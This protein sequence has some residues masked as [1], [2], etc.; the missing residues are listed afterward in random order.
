MQRTMSKGSAKL[1]LSAK[2]SPKQNV[3]GVTPFRARTFARNSAQRILPESN[4]TPTTRFAPANAHST[5]NA[6]FAENRSRTV[7]PATFSRIQG[8]IMRFFISW[9]ESRKEDSGQRGEVPF[10]NLTRVN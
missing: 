8:S 6:P 4:S 3:G 1:W 2:T 7:L 5:A 9:F 10:A